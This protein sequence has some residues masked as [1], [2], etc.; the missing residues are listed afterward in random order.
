MHANRLLDTAIVRY[1]ETT[2]NKDTWKKWNILKT[3]L[4]LVF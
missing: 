4:Y 3:T 1:G 2:E